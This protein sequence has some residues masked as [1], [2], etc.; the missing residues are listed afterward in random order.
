MNYLR[1]VLRL[2]V[3]FGLCLIVFLGP[4]KWGLPLLPP[5][6]A[7]V[8]SGLAEWIMGSW[9][10]QIF[11]YLIFFLFALSFCERCVKYRDTHLISRSA[12]GPVASQPF[13]ILFPVIFLAAGWISA[14]FSVIPARSISLQILYTCYFLFF[15]LL[16]WHRDYHAWFLRAMLASALI[17]ACYGMYQRFAGL[18]QTAEWARLYLSDRPDYATMQA[19][20]ASGRVFSTLVYPNSLGG[21]LV[22]AIPAVFMQ[23]GANRIWRIGIALA[24]M[25][26]ALWFTQSQGS[27]AVLWFLINAATIAWA[28]RN[29]QGGKRMTVFAAIGC[30]SAVLI[31]AGCVAEI[32]PIKWETF[33]MRYTYWAAA[34]KMGLSKWWLG[35]GSGSFGLMYPYFQLPWGG[36]TQM[37][38][39]DVLQIFAETGLLGAIGWVGW[40][41]VWLSRSK[42]PVAP[43]AFAL[44][45]FL[46]HGLIDFDFFVPGITMQAL[47]LLAIL[48]RERLPG[49]DQPALIN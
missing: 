38:H 21:Y 32:F 20:L 44:A 40:W 23:R 3:L 45:G 16:I 11:C 6:A 14:C 1:R 10:T 29:F 4:L 12:A 17:V 34:I 8:P 24:V 46:L 9:P 31:W 5:D 19:K 22:M 27:F 36:P 35:Y 25:L 41:I 7:F 13:S 26:G 47:L 42:I 15:L 33:L 30:V 48:E 28:V 43:I 18:Q 49:Q 37:A 39:C 2:T